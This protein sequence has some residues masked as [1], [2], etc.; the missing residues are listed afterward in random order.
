MIELIKKSSA[1]RTNR[2]R[3]A[4]AVEYAL[5]MGLIVAALIT[6]MVAFGPAVARQFN[7]ACTSLSVTC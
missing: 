7:R 5:I 2:D 3:G 6:I 4:S 1:K